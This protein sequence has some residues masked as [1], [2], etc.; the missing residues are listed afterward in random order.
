MSAHGYRAGINLLQGALLY[1]GPSGTDL[2]L[3]G[4]TMKKVC[5]KPWC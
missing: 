5:R 4:T 2:A 3:L 1:A